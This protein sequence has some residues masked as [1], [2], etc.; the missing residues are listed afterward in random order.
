MRTTNERKS[1]TEGNQMT[2]TADRIAQMLGFEDIGQAIHAETERMR[3]SLLDTA[4]RHGELT[5]FHQTT[6]ERALRIKAEGFKLEHAV[7]PPD[8][9]CFAFHDEHTSDVSNHMGEV[10]TVELPYNWLVSVDWGIDLLA[11]GLKVF[12]DVPADFIVKDYI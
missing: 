11:D 2:D 4:R 5:V 8:A 7:D 1:Y 12:S 9:I 6:R 3:G 10:L